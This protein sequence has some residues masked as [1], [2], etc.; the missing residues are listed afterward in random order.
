MRAGGLFF[1][2][3]WKWWLTKRMHSGNP[4]LLFPQACKSWSKCDIILSCTCLSSL[5][6]H[7]SVIK[8]FLKW[9]TT[10]CS[11]FHLKAVLRAAWPTLKS[12][13]RLK[14]THKMICQSSG[15]EDS[16]FSDCEKRDCIISHSKYTY[17]LW[18]LDNIA[19]LFFSSWWCGFGLFLQSTSIKS[20]E[21]TKLLITSPMRTD[22]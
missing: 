10:T 16:L 3:A 19:T 6:S 1:E 17:S 11:Y 18:T 14:K 21:N 2:R 15:S 12:S 7:T 5:E 8:K 9:K 13:P 4:P 22:S 20:K